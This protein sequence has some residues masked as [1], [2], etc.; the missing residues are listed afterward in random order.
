MSKLLPLH[1]QTPQGGSS[2]WFA[3]FVMVRWEKSAGGK[4][5]GWLPRVGPLPQ[6]ID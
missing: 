6:K 3:R 1:V 2:A 4:A 5:S